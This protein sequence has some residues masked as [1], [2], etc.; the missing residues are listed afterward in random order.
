MNNPAKLLSSFGSDLTDADYQGL[1]TRRITR[2]L[3]DEAGLRRVDS[4]TGR[5]MFG[6]KRGDLAGLIIPNI[7]PGEAQ[8]AGI[9]K[10]WR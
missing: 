7:F 2:K 3:A 10:R 9:R 4:L 5:E 1:A 8:V 6:R